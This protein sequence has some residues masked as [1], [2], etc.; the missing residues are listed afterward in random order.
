MD[1]SDY[2]EQSLSR[3]SREVLTTSL[4]SVVPSFAELKNTSADQ[5]IAHVG[6]VKRSMNN[7][8][9]NRNPI[10]RALWSVKY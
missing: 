7:S 5:M 8:M 9:L 4:Q 1:V 10:L 3:Q 2:A 6:R